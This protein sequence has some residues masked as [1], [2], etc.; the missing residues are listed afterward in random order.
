MEKKL[1]HKAIDL[2]F[3]SV[4]TVSRISPCHFGNENQ[5]KRSFAADLKNEG[6]LAIVVNAEREQENTDYFHLLRY[7]PPLILGDGIL[8]CAGV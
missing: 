2:T 3:K 5:E 8:S 4:E 6:C 7:P 1:C